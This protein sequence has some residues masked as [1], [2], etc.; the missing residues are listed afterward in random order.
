[1]PHS[2]LYGAFRRALQTGRRENLQANQE[3]AVEERNRITRRRFLRATA[4]GAAGG[5]IATALPSE[6]R[7]DGDR[8]PRIAIVGGGIA[9]L[10]AAYQLQLHGLEA[11][12]YEANN[13][14]GGRMF[15]SDKL[16]GDGLVTDLGGSFINGNHADMLSLIRA[17]RLELF[18]RAAYT[19]AQP[20]PEPAYFLG[21]LNRSEAE[22]AEGL[23]PLA[24]QVTLDAD[25]LDEDWERYAPQFDSLSVAQYLDLHADRIPVV[26][27][28]NLIEASIRSEY[29]LEMD[30]CSALELLFNLP[31]VDGTRVDVISTS[32]ES[33][34][35]KHGSGSL[36]EA[37]AQ[38]LR[39]QIQT[40]R[41]LVRLERTG[42]TYRLTFDT[43]GPSLDAP[44]VVEADYVILA[45]PFT[46]LRKVELLVTLPQ[47]L[48][49][50]INEL[51]LGAN[52]KV[53][54]GMRDKFWAREDGFSWSAWTDMQFCNVWNETLRQPERADAA[55]TFYYGGN[56]VITDRVVS[57]RK[58]GT[59][60]LL[61]LD[62]TLPGGLSASNSRFAATRWTS[63]P[64]S[65]GAYPSFK[66]GQFT[67]FADYFYIESDDPEKRQDVHVGNLVFAGDQISDEFFGFMNGAAQTGRLAAETVLRLLRADR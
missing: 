25:L 51:V 23:R 4:A 46:L 36:I 53:F 8:Q 41:Q 50:F 45:I 67:E 34:Q 62:Q 60:A 22:V 39:G 30:D 10:N 55:L 18:D 17:F 35:L 3:P 52:Q 7:A 59:E 54:G 20:Y 26:W 40:H 21:G 6:A 5:L 42:L 64:F 33:F 49:R 47:T 15:T 19:E 28:R 16:V 57:S 44:E 48:R 1:M 9:G 31:T 37:I 12:V 13:R 24:D 63:N 32:D 38:R 61:R 56:Q 27:I 66:P 43:P 14:L 11:T 29:G 2:Q 58:L 65:L